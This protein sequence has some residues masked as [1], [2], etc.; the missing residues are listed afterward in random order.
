MD[1]V[2]SKIQ[3]KGA[4]GVPLL[5]QSDR[6]PRQKIGGITLFLRRLPVT[7]PVE[8]LGSRFHVGVV[9]HRTPQKTIVMIETTS[10]RKIFR[11]GQT[12]FPIPSQMPFAAH[13]RLVTRIL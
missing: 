13:P 11:T 12:I 6:F 10:V 8:F 4:M 1:G 3:K 9:I 2:E 5:N 7:P